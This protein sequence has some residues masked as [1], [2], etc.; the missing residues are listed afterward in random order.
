[1]FVAMC[2][3]LRDMSTLSNYIKGHGEKTRAELAAAFGIS[4]PHLYS[5]IDGTRQPSI[6][7][8]VRIASATNGEVPV[9][10]WP[11]LNAVISAAGGSK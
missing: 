5:L 7:V 11:N 2:D 4:R 8:A 10:S 3:I 6:A 1:M 9:T